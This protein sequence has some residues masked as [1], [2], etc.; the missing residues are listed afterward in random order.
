[1]FYG[2][3]TNFGKPRKM[4]L[5]LSRQMVFDSSYEW[6]TTQGWSFIPLDPYLW[7]PAATVNSQVISTAHPGVGL[8]SDTEV[9][10][11]RAS[12]VRWRRTTQYILLLHVIFLL[13]NLLTCRC[14]LQDYDMAWAQYMGLGVAG[15]TLYFQFLLLQLLL[16]L[17][18]SLLL[19]FA[20]VCWRGP[21]IFEGPVS[22]AIVSSWIGFYKKYRAT[23]TSELLVHV[24]RPDGQVRFT[25]D[26]MRFSV[27]N[28]SSESL[29]FIL[30]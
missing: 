3:P 5:L 27:A 17:L 9:A 21:R 23:L 18:H 11:S 20:A 7:I 30:Q 6:I 15:G 26:H 25:L 14:G 19:I 2:D 12:S 10:A 28:S 16:L 24:R 4:D 8:I 22:K 13:S 1:M 29:L